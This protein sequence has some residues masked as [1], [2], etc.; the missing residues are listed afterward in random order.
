V[1][2]PPP[3]PGAAAGKPIKWLAELKGK[4][5]TAGPTAFKFV[6]P[7]T[8]IKITVEKLLKFHPV[9][10]EPGVTVASVA[11]KAGKLTA[12][13]AVEMYVPAYQG[14]VHK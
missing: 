4:T 13:K 1:V 2:A 8:H 7:A 3:A 14:V 6:V 9:T 10:R 5:P 11:G 12:K